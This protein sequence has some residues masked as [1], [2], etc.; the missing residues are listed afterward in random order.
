MPT[1]Q[2]QC[3]KCKIQYEELTNYDSSG[4]YRD[5]KCPACKSKRKTQQVTCAGIKFTNPKDTSKFDN[6]G[7]RAGYNLEKA[8][9]LRRDA[10]QASHVGST[11]YNQLDDISGGEFFG[12]VE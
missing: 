7:Y 6:F 11:P 3:L 8:Q 9:E 12:E 4:K 10:E 5:V 1:Y 2:F